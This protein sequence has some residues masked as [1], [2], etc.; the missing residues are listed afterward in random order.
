MEIKIY[1]SPE[2]SVLDL[3]S[4]DIITTSDIIGDVTLG[5]NT[6]TVELKGGTWETITE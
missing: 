3:K 1:N 2:I 4:A 6:S 5:T